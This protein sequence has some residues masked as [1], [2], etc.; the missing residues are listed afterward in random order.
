VFDL[1]SAPVDLGPGVNSVSNDQ[2]PAISSDGETLFF[3][4][5]RP[6]G[7]GGI[8]IY[9]TTRTKLRGPQ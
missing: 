9:V 6:G 8:D 5:D 4:S 2:A 7:Y 3:A 1:W